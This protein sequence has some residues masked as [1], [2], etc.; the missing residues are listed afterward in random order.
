M[1]FLPAR[2]LISAGCKQGLIDVGWVRTEG[3]PGE[4][5]P[6]GGLREAQIW[7]AQ[8]EGTV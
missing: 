7:C 5:V 2:R 3:F 6:I 1:T 4:A 8:P